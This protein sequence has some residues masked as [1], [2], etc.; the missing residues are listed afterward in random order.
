[1][2]FDNFYRKNLLKNIVEFEKNI[3]EARKTYK[4]QWKSLKKPYSSFAK[5]VEFNSVSGATRR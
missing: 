1:M 3:L 4:N 5:L 2:L